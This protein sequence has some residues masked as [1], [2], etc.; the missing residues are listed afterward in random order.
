MKKLLLF[1]TFVLL[2]AGGLSS[3]R[4][5][6]GNS[7]VLMTWNVHNLFDGND[8]GFEYPE[9]RQSA[10]WSEEKYKGRIN[11]ISAA[12][13]KLPNAP[14]ILILQEIESLLVLEDIAASLP[15]GYFWGHFAGNPESAIGVGV[16]SRIPI[17]EVF[18]H[19]SVV[20]SSAVPRPVLEVRFDTGN[21]EFIVFACHWKS[22]IGGANETEFLRKA[23]GQIILRRSAEIWAEKPEI[24]IIIAGDL[25][26]RINELDSIFLITGS[27]SPDSDSTYSTN[28]TV[29]F[30]PWLDELSGGTYFYRNNWETIDHFLVS[31]HLLSVY[32]RT[33]I[34]DFEPFA[35][36]EGKP[37]PYNSRTGYG[38]SDHLPLIII[39]SQPL[40]L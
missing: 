6:S 17:T 7:L 21:F 1:L 15:N 27:T 8:D 31:R 13:G 11:A 30:S 35:C 38:L 24:G 12:I 33:Y 18:D 37:V 10:G 36:P 26:M 16:I 2:A 20:G 23:A 5:N 19:G 4:E 29:W 14:D 28:S 39:F 22:K 3:C 34:G 40:R 9:F 25:N 32:Q